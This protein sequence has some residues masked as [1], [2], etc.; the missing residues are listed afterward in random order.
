MI[1]Q[2]AGIRWRD[3]GGS[4]SAFQEAFIGDLKE[5]ETQALSHPSTWESSLEVESAGF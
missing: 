4:P 2:A 3:T 5:H 1:T